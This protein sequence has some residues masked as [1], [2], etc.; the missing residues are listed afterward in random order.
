MPF[1]MSSKR[2]IAALVE[3]DLSGMVYDGI[4]N[5]F[6]PDILNAESFW[7]SPDGNYYFILDSSSSSRR[8]NRYDMSIPWDITSAPFNPNQ[9]LVYPSLGSRKYRAIT[10]AYNGEHF[11]TIDDS[12]PQVLRQWTMSTP[13]DLTTGS[14][15]VQKSAW[16]FGL[17]GS[18][19]DLAISD[20]GSILMVHTQFASQEFMRLEFGTSYNLNTISGIIEKAVVPGSF[21][22]SHISGDGTTFA[23]MKRLSPNWNP[24]AGVFSSPWDLS[25][26]P[27]IT[28]TGIATNTENS[29]MIDIFIKPDGTKLWL[30]SPASR[31]IYQYSI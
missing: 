4:S 10:F 17:G 28:S 23:T 19:R 22:S 14:L 2:P 29:S 18:V 25:P 13:W 27:T 31:R 26:A 1:I 5:A 11:Y 20:D 15:V 16:G 24:T 21:V 6:A 8:I 30:I 7:F 12:N 3:W 9:T